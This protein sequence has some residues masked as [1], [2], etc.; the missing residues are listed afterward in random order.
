[1]TSIETFYSELAQIRE[2]FHKYGKFD[3]ANAKLDEIA[4][5]ITMYVYEVQKE[6][7]NINNLIFAYEQNN[8]YQLVIELKQLFTKITAYI[9]I[10]DK[11]A[12]L[13]IDDNDNH[14]AYLLLKLV[15]SSVDRVL[16]DSKNFDLLNE[17]FGHFIRDSFRNHIEDAQYMT[18]YEAVELMCEMALFDLKDEN[19][20]TDFTILDP[21]CGVGS[22][23]STFYQKNN[24][25][26]KQQLR[27]IG[28]DK[29]ERMVKLSKI[30][31]FLANIQNQV[32]A[33]NNS[34]VGKSFLDNYEG[35]IDLILT[36]PPFG[37]KFSSE[38]LKPDAKQH[39]P[40]LQDLIFKNGT[41]FS[42]EILFIDRCLQLLKP[43][44]KLLAVVPDSVISSAGLANMLRYR[45]AYKKN[46]QVKAIIELPAVTFAQAGT[47][48][49][50][51]ILYLQKTDT[52]HKATFMAKCENIGF[53]V[54]T[55]KGATVKYAEGENE[56]PKILE[57]YKQ[58][59]FNEPIEKELILSKQPSCVLINSE[60]LK[61]QSWT[62]SHYNAEKYEA[63]N[64]LQNNEIQLVKLSEIAKFE[65]NVRKK[66]LILPES[67][68]ISVLHIVNGDNLN[69]EEL[70]TYNP[71]YQGT[72]CKGGDLLFSKINPR[73]LRV[74][75]VPELDFPLTC[76]SEFEIMNSKTELSNY[77]LK[78][79]LM[80]P[81]VQTQI[82]ATTSGTSSSHNRIKAQDLGNIL[83]PLP[84]KNTKKY[85]N[86]VH[87]ALIYEQ[88]D[89]QFN[90]LRFEMFQ[91]KNEVFELTV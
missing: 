61:I 62:A 56:L 82:N 36:N 24:L 48:T 1:M 68:C 6:Q 19:I 77:A 39:Y 57:A 43:N 11:K 21:C 44:G 23:L 83:I 27:L 81:Y 3:D 63:I 18:P 26:D 50:T 88:K 8:D 86:L 55:K 46:V 59:K 60:L 80:L 49:K 64:L 78:L 73:I 30:N 31:L 34:L 14:F 52:L 85:E 58:T 69:Y 33:N 25:I 70:L 15:V 54:S 84:Q 4:K 72:V 76:S 41:N 35:K 16:N 37:A 12:N 29:V 53:E 47:R 13:N 66:E 65:T 17:C 10:F 71:K 9:D 87:K 22:F 67:K 20:D 79:L 91:L 45:L 5:Y 7:K 89:K 42:S 90:H 28:Q 2:L 38:E 51:S 74:L 75:V 40:L 32:I